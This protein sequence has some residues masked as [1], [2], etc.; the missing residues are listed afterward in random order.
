MP[1]QDYITN[2]SLQS[3]AVKLRYLVMSQPR[4]GSSLICSALRKAGNAGR[5]TEF[6]HKRLTQLLPQPLT[7]NI[8]WSYYNDILARETSSNGVFGMKLHF[9]QFKDLFMRQNVVTNDGIAFLKS[10]D[11]TILVSREDKIAQAISLMLAKKHERWNSSKPTDAGSQNLKFQPSDAPIILRYLMNVMAD[12]AAWV[13]L[14]EGLNLRPLEITYE[15]ISVF[16]QAE[17]NR[18]FDH[19]GL[20]SREVTPDTVKLSRD[21]HKESKSCFLKAIGAHI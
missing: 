4:T 8:L 14:S 21:N 1:E 13:Q 11:K 18:I 12:H 17:L 7:S 20:P 9:G 3:S 5:P 6:L 19:L 15:Q 16:P 10:F 2:L